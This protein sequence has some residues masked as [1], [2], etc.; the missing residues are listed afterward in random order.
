LL[1]RGVPGSVL[2]AVVD[3]DF[4]ESNLARSDLH[5]V[6]WI[7]C[8]RYKIYLKMCRVLSQVA[9]AAAHILRDV[10]PRGGNTSQRFNV[11][12]LKA[13]AIIRL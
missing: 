4:D 11:F 10:L 7:R 2:V 13:K 6:W 8:A 9:G 3:L 12:H 1:D 5:P